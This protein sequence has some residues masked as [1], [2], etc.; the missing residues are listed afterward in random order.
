MK[1]QAGSVMEDPVEKTSTQ[2]IHIRECISEPEDA[3]NQLHLPANRDHSEQSE[4]PAQIDA[5]GE[6]QPESESENANLG[7]LDDLQLA[8]K[9]LR[10]GGIV[11]HR[12]IV[13][14]CLSITAALVALSL[15]DLKSLIVKRAEIDRSL[16]VTLLADRPEL[17]T[18][19]SYIDDGPGEDGLIKVQQSGLP[20]LRRMGFADDSGRIVFSSQSF[21][22]ISNF[23]D[24]LARVEETG[25]KYGFIDKSG[26]FVI[27][28]RFTAAEDFDDGVALVQTPGRGA[29]IDTA[30]RELS[31][32]DASG[33]YGSKV[34][35]LY[36]FHSADGKVGLMNKHGRILQQ[37]QY[38]QILPL[39][40]EQGIS[41]L[42]V[43]ITTYGGVE[44]DGARLHSDYIYVRK[45][46]HW[47]VVDPSGKTIVQPDFEKIELFYDL[48][49][50]SVYFRVHK[51]HL[52]GLLSSSGQM[53]LPPTFQSLEG[54][55]DGKFIASSKG[56]YPEII[57]SKTGKVVIAPQAQS[58][59][60]F[61][62]V[63]AARRGDTWS[64][65]NGKGQPIS[66]PKIDKIITS[67]TGD[68]LCEGLGA[69]VVNGKVGFVNA[70]GEMVIKPQ[71]QYATAFHDGLSAVW[72]GTLWQFIDRSGKFISPVKFAQLSS[73]Q[74]GKASVTLPG[75]LYA[76]TRRRD[77]ENTNT[78][79]DVTGPGSTSNYYF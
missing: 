7:R 46:S 63:I 26:H 39:P 24:G 40:V 25:A 55:K 28:P 38:D 66:A 72:D 12:V 54:I 4:P 59:T 27:E 65:L 34:G 1:L 8:K 31:S 67:K 47:G 44:P 70:R 41:P 5:K 45:N 32:W 36:A 13:A 68:W 19:W 64:L 51:D 17:P 73:F 23:H 10:S 60:P 37:P 14:A 15:T 75:P 3:G 71:Y 79:T 20:A 61:D 21:R 11:R 78:F 50:S 22:S 53:L 43:R 76:F 6:S 18:G 48:K 33:Q 56:G 52:Y 74:N 29:L 30:G 35:Q 9:R 58:I 2:K 77:I 57:D 69:V 62:S 42:A 16:H 49:N